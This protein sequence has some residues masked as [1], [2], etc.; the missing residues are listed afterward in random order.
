MARKL[1][2]IA[3]FGILIAAAAS[4]WPA[5]PRASANGGVQVSPAAETIQN[6]F[7]PHA[8]TTQPTTAPPSESG[9]R[10]YQNPFSVSATSPPALSP[11]NAGILSRWRRPTQLPG[12]FPTAPAASS[13]SATQPVINAWDV[14]SPSQLQDAQSK[15]FLPQADQ[16]IAH[17][18]A[19]PDPIDYG[20]NE[21]RQPGWLVPS[22]AFDTSDAA[23]PKQRSYPHT[24]INVPLPLRTTD[25]GRVMPL[26]KPMNVPPFGMRQPDPF[27]TA[28]AS[29]SVVSDGNT[30]SPNRPQ[31]PQFI[32]PETRITATASQPPQSPQVQ[33]NPYPAAT[34]SPADCYDRAQHAAET[35]Q[36]ADELSQVV[37]LCQQGLSAQPPRDLA[38]R[39]RSLAAWARNRHGELQSDGGNDAEALADFNDALQ[40]DPNCWLALH[41]RAV[42]FAQQ[43]HGADAFRDFNR[44]IQLSP[45]MAIA[46]RN[47]GELLASMGRTEEAVADYGRAIAQLPDEADLYQIRG[48]ALHRLGRYQDALA[49]LDHAIQLTPRDADTFTHRGN[50]YA[51][52]GNY[53]QAID[54][55]HQALKLNANCAD[56]YRSL[57][58]L[59]STCPNP[60]FR[61]TQQ[62]L[63]AAERAAK[64]SPQGDCFVLDALAAAHA[65]AGDFERA[66]RYQK[67]AAAVAPKS[68]SPQYAER[69]ALYQQHRPYRNQLASTV[70]DREVRAASLDAASAAAEPR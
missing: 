66:V 62:A 36:S 44:V 20:P 42:S 2:R 61:D 28:E 21:L 7:T 27:E 22:P 51:E 10:I 56:A 29:N 64:L 69:L 34:A 49:D 68:F 17:P 18:S 47:R 60:Q 33:N 59:Q 55:F 63:A 37:Q 13:A 1:S 45:G 23:P 67:E 6:P 15:S 30:A 4:A 54:D 31:T 38:P 14:L 8:P 9:P 57:A 19:P 25:A 35:A 41:N 70:P 43:G 39:L 46:Y 53:N 48:H 12:S 24:S 11:P 3:Q 65:N 32:Q 16:Q 50:V 58:W 26:P 52:L 40:L 5:V